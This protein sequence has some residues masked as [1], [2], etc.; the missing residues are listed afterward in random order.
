MNWQEL[1]IAIKR[2]SK[3]S[4]TQIARE[5]GLNPSTLWSMHSGRHA[6]DPKFSIGIILIQFAKECNADLTRA[7]NQ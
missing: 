4:L 2:A 1:T 7:I 6:T 3:K 5:L